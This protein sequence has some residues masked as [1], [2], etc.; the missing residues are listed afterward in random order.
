MA[1]VTLVQYSGA[2][3]T[4]TLSSW[5]VCSPTRAE[6]VFWRTYFQLA[7]WSSCIARGFPYRPSVL[8]AQPGPGRRSPNIWNPVQGLEDGRS[9]GW[10][11]CWRDGQSWSRRDGFAGGVHCPAG[12]ASVTHV[13]PRAQTGRGGL[14]LGHFGFDAS[15]VILDPGHPLARGVKGTSLGRPDA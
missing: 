10:A 2:L 7:L 14:H 8:G 4:P 1:T 13:E 11:G 9:S 12:W 3:A 6:A 15:L 5:L